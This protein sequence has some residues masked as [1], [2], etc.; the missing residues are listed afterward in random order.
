M[1]DI[2]VGPGS[3]RDAAKCS[4]D[5]A[6]ELRGVDPRVADVIALAMRESGSAFNAPKVG[7]Y[8][9]EKLGRLAGALDDRADKLVGAADLY[10][11]GER[12]TSADF[13]GK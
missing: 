2:D 13:D 7:K 9:R 10:D 3:L 6:G 8:W 4:R 5:L 12:E 11:R 1:P